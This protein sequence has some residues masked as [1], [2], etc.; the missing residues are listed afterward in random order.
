MITPKVVT[1]FL[2]PTYQQA[3]SSCALPTLFSA[4][5]ALKPLSHYL[6]LQEHFSPSPPYSHQGI[7]KIQAKHDWR[8][9]KKKQQGIRKP[10]IQERIYQARLRMRAAV[11]QPFEEA[12]VS[13]RVKQ[14]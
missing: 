9:R 8:H 5:P 10:L 7:N 12:P 4:V 13:H 1:T 11:K 6:A 2:S 3:F 14:I